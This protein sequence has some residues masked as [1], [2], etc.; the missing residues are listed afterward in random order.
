MMGNIFGKILAA[1]VRVVAIAADAL[2]P[3]D[4]LDVAGYAADLGDDIEEE[5][6][7]IFGDDE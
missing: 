3:L 4:I 6:E 1:P 7:W 5:V 2:E